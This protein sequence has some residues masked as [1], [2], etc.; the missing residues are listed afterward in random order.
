MATATSYNGWSN[1]PTWNWKLWID[2]QGFLAYWQDCARECYQ[3][4]K[5]RYDWQSIDQVATSD[6]ADMLKMA[7]DELEAGAFRNTGP[8]SDILGWALGQI[9]FQAIAASVLDDLD[10]NE[11]KALRADDDEPDDA[12]PVTG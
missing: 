12:E 1:Y 9:D 4:A 10:D 5:P 3:H 6:L 7:A 8:L 11:K 2:S